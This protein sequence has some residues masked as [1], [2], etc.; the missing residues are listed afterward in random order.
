MWNTVKQEQKV[1]INVK[2]GV[3]LNNLISDTGLKYN[4]I[5]FCSL[6]RKILVQKGLQYFC[7]VESTDIDK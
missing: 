6:T 2:I 7:I 3:V 1:S 4:K 5:M